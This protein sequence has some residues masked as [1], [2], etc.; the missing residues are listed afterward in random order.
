MTIT[1]TNF[2][3]SDSITTFLVDGFLY[4]EGIPMSQTV[5]NGKFNFVKKQN[6]LNF[7]KRLFV[8]TLNNTQ[9]PRQSK[10]N[11]QNNFLIVVSKQSILDI[12]KQL[13]PVYFPVQILPP[14]DIPAQI[15]STDISAQITPADIS[16]Q[17]PLEDIP[18]QTPANIPIS[19]TLQTTRADSRKQ[20]SRLTTRSGLYKTN[21]QLES[22][23]LTPTTG[24]FMRKTTKRIDTRKQTS[25]ARSDL[26]KPTLRPI[27]QVSTRKPT[28]RQMHLT[29]NRRQTPR[30]ST[31]TDMKTTPYRTTRT[32]KQGLKQMECIIQVRTSSRKGQI[33]FQ[34]KKS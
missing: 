7:C 20:T 4:N 25:T 26:R 17:I 32:I 19:T 24:A 29:D 33:G 21:P 11:E 6:L 31:R 5:K 1:D 30:S 12:P 9:I 28:P 10:K 14:A 27:T 13:P 3:E 2:E 15:P 23:K 34:L 16:A 8:F 18:V 22:R